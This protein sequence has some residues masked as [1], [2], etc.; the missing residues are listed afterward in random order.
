MIAALTSWTRSPFTWIAAVLVAVAAGV[1]LWIS[2][3]RDDAAGPPSEVTI[4]KVG[5]YCAV[6][7]TGDG[8]AAWALAPGAV[9]G[10]LHRV[11]PADVDRAS[12]ECR[13]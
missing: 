1:S 5:G 12:A 7:V 9:D 8:G 4:A 13:R 11:D 2:P 6:T 10:Q 3:P